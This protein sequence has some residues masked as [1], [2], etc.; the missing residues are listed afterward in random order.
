MSDGAHG[1]EPDS[2]SGVADTDSMLS[3][4]T[5]LP[6]VPGG[7]RFHAEYFEDTL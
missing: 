4:V 6:E 7:F 5:H 2:R 3:Q 1:R